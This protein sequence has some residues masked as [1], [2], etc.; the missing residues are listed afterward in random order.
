[1]V[2]PRACHNALPFVG[3]DE[4]AGDAP[5]A[6]TKSCGIPTPTSAVF[7]V[8]TPASA[9]TPA[10]TQAPTQVLGSPSLYID[11]DLQRATKLALD[12]FIKGQEYG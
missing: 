12:L 5:G 1:M 10:L 4:L 11:A 8:P 9:Q 2:R 7:C 6:H 3:K